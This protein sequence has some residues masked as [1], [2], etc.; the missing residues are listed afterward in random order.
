MIEQVDAARMQ[1]VLAGRKTRLQRLAEETPEGV[2]LSP[3]L[4]QNALLRDVRLSGFE[5]DLTQRIIVANHLMA[6]SGYVTLA[7]MLPLLLSLKGKPYNLHNHFPFEPFF[8]TRMSKKT[9]LKTGRQVSKSTSLASQGVLFSNCIDYFSTLYVTPL[10]EMVRR[11]SQNYVRPFIETSP[12][13]KLFSG[14]KTIN[15][16]LQRS[17]KNRSQM[18]FSFAFLDAERTRGIAADKNVIDEIQEMDIDFL[19]IIHETMSGSEDW[20]IVQYAGTPKT[21]DNTI[22]RLWTDTSMAEWMIKCPHGGCGHWNVPAL[23]HDLVEMIGPLHDFISE[24]NPGIVC[25]KCRKPVNPRPPSQ[26]GTGRWVHRI[27]SKRWS[28]AGYHVPQI[29]MPMHYANAEKWEVLLGKQAGKGNTPIHVF[30][31]E[32]CGESYDS[33]SKMVT[34]TDLK[35]AAVLPWRNVVDQA[36]QRIGEYVYRICAVD[37]GGGGVNKGRSDLMY[38]SYTSIAVMG[39][40]PTG[41]FHTIYGFRSLHPHNHVREA[42]IILGI[43]AKFKCSHMIHDYTGAG[44]V[45]ETVIHQAGLPTE[46]I[47]PVALQGASKGGL[48]VPKEATELHPR[49]HYRCDKPRSLNL[50]CQMIKSGVLKFYQYD[51]VS[52]DDPGLLHDFLNLIEEK[53]DSRTGGDI[54]TIIRDPAGPDDFAQAVNLGVMGLSQMSGAWPDLAKYEEIE[55]SDEALAAASPIQVRDWDDLP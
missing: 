39:L 22:E 20:G 43:M 32:V 48:F 21:L 35:K 34:I 14:S 24:R 16:V 19:P 7:P 3:L 45:R 6:K 41:D 44:T 4:Q 8:R 12:V 10:F 49:F 17:F 42:R 29:I 25:G 36:V 23:E 38:N 27:K 15:S 50:T 26:G 55:I 33:G 9:L 28:F 31:N 5:D 53:S 18:I 1:E 30:F 2:D 54:Y 37:W 13:M 40:M 11:F 52:N 46:R 47:I 51:H